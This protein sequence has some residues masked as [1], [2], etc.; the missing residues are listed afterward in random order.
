MASSSHGRAVRSAHG[1]DWQSPAPD[2]AEPRPR[3]PD[4]AN[5]EKSLSVD[6]DAPDGRL[7]NGRPRP[8][9]RAVWS[10]LVRSDL[11]AGDGLGDVRC[12]GSVRRLVDRKSTRLNSSHG[13]ISY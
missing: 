13:Y 11:R 2:K 10:L 1:Q 4:A 5:V 7:C 9:V 12:G 8:G 3:H 6:A